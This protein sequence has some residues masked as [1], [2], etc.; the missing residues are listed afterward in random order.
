MK[1]IGILLLDIG[2]MF[3]RYIEDLSRYEQLFKLILSRK[4][5]S[6]KREFQKGLEWINK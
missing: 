5:H 4:L 2:I 1:I 3:G 6:L